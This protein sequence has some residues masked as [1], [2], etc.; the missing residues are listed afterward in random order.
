[1]GVRQ[2]MLRQVVLIAVGIP[3][4]KK[5]LL[6]VG[7]ERLQVGIAGQQIVQFRLFFVRGGKIE[8]RDQI[9]HVRAAFPG[10]DEHLGII[11]RQVAACV[12]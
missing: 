5:F 2:Q 7:T 3:R 6:L 9:V 11:L 10:R 8:E 12:V 4:G 1:M